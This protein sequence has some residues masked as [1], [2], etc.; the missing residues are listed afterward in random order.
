MVTFGMNYRVKDH[1]QKKFLDTASDVVQYAQSFNGHRLTRILQDVH[2]PNL[3]MIYSE[4]QSMAQFQ[5]F[6]HS[7]GFQNTTKIAGDMLLERP[8]HHIFQSSTPQTLS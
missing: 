5:S 1:A 6:L 7:D 3:F 2:E 4:W 8:T